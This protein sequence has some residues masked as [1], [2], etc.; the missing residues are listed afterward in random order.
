MVCNV[1]RSTP[2]LCQPPTATV[3]VLTASQSCIQL[4]RERESSICAFLLFLLPKHHLPFTFVFHLFI[5]L[6]V[7]SV[8]FSLFSSSVLKK[9]NPFPHL[10]LPSYEE[11]KSKNPKLTKEYSQKIHYGAVME[12]H[13]S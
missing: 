5:L 12:L 1:A 4:V 8:S 10:R 7:Y 13:D 11:Q 2:S 6:L 3:K 9:K